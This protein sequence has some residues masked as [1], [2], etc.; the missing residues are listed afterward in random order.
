MGKVYVSGP[1]TNADP[2][3]QAD[4]LR[5]FHAA[6]AAPVALGYVVANPAKNGLP[7]SAPWHEHMRADI[8]ML[9]DCGAVCLLPGWA[10][11]RGANVEHDLARALGMQVQS[12]A[13]F[14]PA[15]A[16]LEA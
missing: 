4:S 1:I 16:H 15:S 13:W 8:R 3:V 6:E 5:R 7:E 11:S 10:N 14:Q 12:L 2:R 9:M